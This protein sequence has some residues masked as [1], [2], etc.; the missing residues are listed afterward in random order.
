MLS[1]PSPDGEQNQL[2]RQFVM[3]RMRERADRAYTTLY[4]PVTLG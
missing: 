1:S 3:A 4:L 2:V